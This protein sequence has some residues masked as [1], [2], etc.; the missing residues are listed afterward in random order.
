[1]SIGFTTTRLEK[2]VWL[3]DIGLFLSFFV[4]TLPHYHAIAVKCQNEDIKN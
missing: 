3:L 2:K 4:G 1:M